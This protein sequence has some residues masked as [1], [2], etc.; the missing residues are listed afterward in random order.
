MNVTR[1]RWNERYSPIVL[2][3]DYFKQTHITPAL[4]GEI[5]KGQL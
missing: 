4:G 2:T 5:E 1:V 3:R